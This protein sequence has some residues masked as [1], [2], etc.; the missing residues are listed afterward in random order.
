[1][2]ELDQILIATGV[3]LIG[4]SMVF[5]APLAG[6]SAQNAVLWGMLLGGFVLLVGMLLPFTGRYGDA[7]HR[8]SRA[9]RTNCPHC[10]SS[11]ATDA[12]TCPHCDAPI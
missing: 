9:D 7:D 12:T 10:G 5:V 11:A 6:V 3:L 4:G 8:Y 2:P 1:M